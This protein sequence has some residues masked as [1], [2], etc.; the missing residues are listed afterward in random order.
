MIRP[1]NWFDRTFTFDLPLGAY[2]GVIERLRGTPA[3]LAERLL[4]FPREILTRR[5]GEDWSMQEHAG[6][7]WDL[8]ALDKGRLDDFEAGIEVLRSADLENR[9]TWQANHNANTIEKILAEFQAER[10][11]VVARLESFDEAFV[12]RTALHPRLK[13][14]MRVIDLAYFIAEHDDHHLAQIAE[15]I[16]KFKETD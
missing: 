8:D 12:Q 16:R 11:Q 2:A 4:R 15:L 7:L 1:L 13:T 10:G 3:R 6:H 5:D 14:P 9:K